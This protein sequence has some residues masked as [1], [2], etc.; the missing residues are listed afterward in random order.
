M[1]RGTLRGIHDFRKHWNV[2]H[3]INEEAVDDPLTVL[4]LLVEDSL[5]VLDSPVAIADHP[6]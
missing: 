6:L 1:L 2:H 3:V 5:L 4:L